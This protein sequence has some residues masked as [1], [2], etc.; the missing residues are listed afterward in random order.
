MARPIDFDIH[1]L[2]SDLTGTCKTIDEFL[3]EGMS[4]E[5]LTTEDH[6]H[7]DNEIF[8]CPT[9]GWWCSVDEAR[10]EEGDESTCEDCHSDE[11][12]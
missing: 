12:E 1:Q 9:C 11:E 3:P 4:E 2:V 10:G 5:D 7:I 8:L 6:A